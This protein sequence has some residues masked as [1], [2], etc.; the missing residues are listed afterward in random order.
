MDHR[1]LL[2]LV[3]I[4][5]A[6]GGFTLKMLIASSSPA[7]PVQSGVPSATQPSAPAAKHTATPVGPTWKRAEREWLWNPRKGV[8]FELPSVNRV[9]VWQGTVLPTLVVRCESNRMQTFVYTGSAMQMEPQDENHTVRIRFDDEPEQTARWAD[10]S[11]HSALF[12]PDA[13]GFAQRLTTAR[14][15]RFSYTPHNAATAVAEF[16]VGGLA[17]LIQ[18]AAKQCGLRSRQR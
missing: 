17:D 7:V 12:A 14:T 13:A 1:V 8:A 11:D 18:P 3:L 6:G 16:H 5:V 4:T 15:L 2:G 10:D 9:A